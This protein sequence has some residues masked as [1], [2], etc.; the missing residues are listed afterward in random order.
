M[1]HC[2]VPSQ[3]IFWSR[4]WVCGVYYEVADVTDIKQV[5]STTEQQ[6]HRRPIRVAA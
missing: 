5:T 3:L 2:I 4:H 6:P 1:G